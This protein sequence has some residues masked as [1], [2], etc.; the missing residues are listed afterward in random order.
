MRNLYGPFYD[1]LSEPANYPVVR[2]IIIVGAGLLLI[3]SGIFFSTDRG[4][5]DRYT[6]STADGDF[7]EL[8]PLDAST[9]PSTLEVGESD[10]EATAA[11]VYDVKSGETLYEQNADEVLPLASVTKL[12]TALIVAELVEAGEVITVS[13]EAVAQYGNSGLRVGERITADN[14]MVYALLS[15]SNDAAYALA[16]SIGDELFPGEGSEAFIDAMNVR[17]EELGLENTI[18][19]NPTGLDVSNVESGAQG[20]AAD[21]NKLMAHLLTEHPDLLATTQTGATRIYNEDGDFH[22][23]ANTNRILQRI[24]SLLGSKTGFTD[25]AGGNLT[26]AYD[27]GL[28]RPIII[29]V[30]GSSFVGRFQDVE[31]LLTATQQAWP[32]PE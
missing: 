22:E 15:S 30:L 18:F 32:D 13:A 21:I 24:P 4:D 7:A 14:L 17:A 20:T 2:Q 28:N 29:T 19:Q 3:F 23:A 26:I 1:T 5:S 12:M 10:I 16:A 8:P 25:L 31:T 27:A 6:A 11:Y 9:T